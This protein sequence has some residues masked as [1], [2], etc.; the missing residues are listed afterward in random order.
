MMTPVSASSILLMIS[1]MDF[2][3]GLL[4][5]QEGQILADGVDIQADYSG[6][7][8]RLGYIPQMIILLNDTIRANVAFG[9]PKKD[10]LDAQVWRALEEAQ[11]KAFVE[12]LPVGLDATSGERG[13]FLFM[14]E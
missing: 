11:L 2:L 9:I 12:S 4:R 6:W 13:G 3:L 10:V 5:P 8:S 14:A 1:A 7:L